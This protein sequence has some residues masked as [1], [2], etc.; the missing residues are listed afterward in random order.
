MMWLIQRELFAVRSYLQVQK[1]KLHTEQ[2]KKLKK[3]KNTATILMGWRWVHGWELCFALK[4]DISINK[5]RVL[6]YKHSHVSSW[7]LRFDILFSSLAHCQ[8]V[9][10]CL[11]LCSQPPVWF[12]P[13]STHIRVQIENSGQR[14]SQNTCRQ[15]TSS[16]IRGRIYSFLKLVAH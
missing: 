7:Q 1:W 9:N 15:H 2:Q 13:L 14:M 3:K 10:A 11:A 16:G 4:S 8:P 12:Y 5:V 6:C